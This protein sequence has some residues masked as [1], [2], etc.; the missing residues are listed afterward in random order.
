MNNIVFDIL[1][2][3]LVCYYIYHYLQDRKYHH[4]YACVH[5]VREMQIY[6]PS[7][8]RD[9]SI[10]LQNN[11][12]PIALKGGGYS[13]GG[14][15]L[16][17]GGIQID[18][19]NIRNISY[20]KATTY[21]T[22][23]AGCIWHDVLE[24]L[25]IHERTV[26]EMQSFYNFTVG[27]SIAVN[28]HG[29]GLRFGSISDTIVSL[30]VMT[31]KGRI[32]DCTPKDEHT[33]LFKTVVGGYGIVAIICEATLITIPND[34][35][36]L[37][38]N[39]YNINRIDQ[40]IERIST[41]PLIAYWNANIYPNSDEA[42]HSFEWVQTS[43]PV[44][45]H[46]TVHPFDA[47]YPT[48]MICEQLLRRMPLLK[49]LRSIFEPPIS[50]ISRKN[51]VYH[52]SYVI[53]ENVNKL[54]VLSKHPTTTVLQEYF[55]PVKKVDGILRFLLEN[56]RDI[57]CINISL[58]YVKQITHSLLSYAPQD[59]ISIVLYFNVWNTSS[60][61]SELRGWTNHMIK[62]VMSAQGHFYLP[63]LLCYNPV[64]IKILYPNFGK[65]V[66]TK[67]TYDPE[68]ILRNMMSQHL[69]IDNKPKP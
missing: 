56:I 66:K 9:L 40:L 51:K 46:T 58:R 59:S 68:G 34:N 69:D 25:A 21:V 6:C 16:I 7:S 19:K 4:D 48:Y 13:H 32:I 49:T 64:Y 27:G 26:A 35:L 10:F 3:A 52:R 53:A 17:E 14:Q 55:V 45:E 1:I 60:A 62:L 20:D 37:R 67:A 29:R 36:F 42:I 61:I 39:R 28:C 50:I 31:S 33:D 30:K 63:Y 5:R 12:S 2:T 8:I 41:D 38:V 43:D 57:N 18:M 15:T 47:S 54:S 65:F 22:L 24:H 11:S 44:T 23:G